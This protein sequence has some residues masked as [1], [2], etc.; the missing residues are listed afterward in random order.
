LN[1]WCNKIIVIFFFTQISFSQIYE[2]G[3]SYGKSNFIGDVG[4]TRF[5]NPI[6]DAFGGIFKWNRSPRHSYRLSYIRSKLSANDLESSDPRRI[7]RGYYFETPID[8]FLL[9]MEF[10]FFD[11]DLH[12]S[13][14]A[15]SPYIFSG[16]SYTSFKDQLLINSAINSLENKNWTFGI[17]M[18]LGIKYRFYDNYILSIEIGARYTFSDKIDGNNVSNDYLNYNF[19]NI[20]N[21]DWYMFTKIN[22]TYTFGRNPCYCNIGR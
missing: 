12:E 19:G 9:G 6:D 16:I 2:L 3:V 7:E 1:N 15:F 20:N 11:F 17:P 5:I 18:I 21:N 22:L 10:N 4:N 8:E 13:D 14:V